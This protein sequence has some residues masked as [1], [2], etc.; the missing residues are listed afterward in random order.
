MAYTY[1]KWQIITTFAISERRLCNSAHL[2]LWKS[3]TPTV[4]N[5]PLGAVALATIISAAETVAAQGLAVD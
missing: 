3:P 2:M 4:S 5:R 1:S